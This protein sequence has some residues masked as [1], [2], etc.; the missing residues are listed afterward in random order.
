VRTVRIGLSGP[1]GC[2]KSTI[3]RWLAEAG[4]AVIDADDVARRVTDPG[5]PAYR[6]V[7]DRFGPGIVAGDGSI[8]RA[9]LAAIVFADTGA[10]RALE[11]IVHP[12]VRPRIEEAV[13]TAEGRGARAVVIEAIKLVEGGLAAVCD[14]IWLVTCGPA[15]QRTRLAGRGMDP[16]DVERRIATQAGLTERLEATATRVIATDGALDATRDIV[17]AAY[18]AAIG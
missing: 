3:A 10:L 6:A 13:A 2:G 9:A 15:S 8:D 14:E 12:A 16:A 7:V 17:M 1:I 18:A 11:A 4:A 5:G